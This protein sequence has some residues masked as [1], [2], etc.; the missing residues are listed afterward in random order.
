MLSF[1]VTGSGAKPL[2]LKWWKPT[3]KEWAPVLLKDHQVPWR[4]ESDPT[5]GRPWAPLSAKYGRS[6]QK[7]W[8]GAPILR[9]TGD[10]QDTAV[11][12]PWKDGFQ[13]K[14]TPYGAYNQFGTSKMPARPW[15]GI[16]DKSLEQIVPIAWKNILPSKK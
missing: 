10:M 8:P 9:A 3:Q 11:I 6:K 2:N 13:V 5:T 7:R 12:L 14:T 16:P 1:K 4:R 15:M